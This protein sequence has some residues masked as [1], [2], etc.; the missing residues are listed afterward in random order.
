MNKI[1]TSLILI[2]LS[3]MAFS[4][5]KFAKDIKQALYIHDTASN[6]PSEVVALNAFTALVEKYPNEWLPS[7]WAA[8]L[9]TQIARLDGRADGFPKDL[10][11]KQLIV[12]S[13]KFYDRAVEIKGEMTDLEKSDFLMLEAFIY[14]WFMYIVAEDEVEKAKYTK[15]S[16]A[17]YREAAKLNIR[18]PLMFVQMG[19]SLIQ[20]EEYRDVLSGI[21]LLDHAEEIYIRAENRGLTTYWNQDFIKYWRG[22]GEERAQE[23][24]M[25]PLKEP[26][27][28]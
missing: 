8:Y 18:N 19:I 24:M 3:T 28:E 17:T 12:E 22:R 26:S 9:C 7:Y 11:G 15:L 20:R 4:Q 21:G 25:D 1:I 5:K 27:G 23:L 10:N 14:G 16:K 6:V 13:K 2:L